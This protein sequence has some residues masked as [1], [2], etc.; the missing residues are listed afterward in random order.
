[1]PEGSQPF[2]SAPDR[3]AA[4]RLLARVDLPVDD[5][6]SVDLSDFLACGP[7]DDPVGLV[8]LEIGPDVALLR[9]LAVDPAYRGTGLGRALVARAESHAA[10]RGAR[11]VY[12]LTL[13]AETFFRRQGYRDANREAAPP[14]IRAT[15]EFAGICPASAVFLCKTL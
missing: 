11:A 8:G 10:D 7:A 14:F 2:F 12:L 13:T 5:L 3:E 15:P 6:A 1:M 4:R 9:S